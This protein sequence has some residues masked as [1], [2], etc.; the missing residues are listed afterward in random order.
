MIITVAFIELNVLNQKIIFRKIK[1]ARMDTKIFALFSNK[2]VLHFDI[3]LIKSGKFH[4][5]G[6]LNKRC[7][8]NF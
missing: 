2:N 5:K 1:F 3:S 6:L 4:F 8:V 7:N